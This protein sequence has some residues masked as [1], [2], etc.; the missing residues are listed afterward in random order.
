MS[1]GKTQKEGHICENKP[2]Y[3]NAKLTKYTTGLAVSN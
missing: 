3:Q 1:Y 2:G